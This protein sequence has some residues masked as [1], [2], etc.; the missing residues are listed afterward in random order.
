MAT[1]W[2]DLEGKF[3]PLHMLNPCRLDYINEQIAIEF[4]KDLTQNLPFKGLRILDIGW[5]DKVLVQ[6]IN[7][8]NY[9]L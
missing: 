8:L 9:S 1:E 4:N 5:Y 6:V 3:K 7:E 2:W